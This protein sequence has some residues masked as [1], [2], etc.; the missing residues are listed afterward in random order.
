MGKAPLLRR[1][2]ALKLAIAGG[3]LGLASSIVAIVRTTTGYGDAA[4]DDASRAKLIALAP[5]QLIVVKHLARRVCAADQ[6]GVVT[7]DETDVAG[8]VDAYVAKMPPKLR[9]DLLR[10][11]QYIEQLAPVAIGMTSRFT[12]LSPPDQDKVLASIESSSIELLRGGFDGVKALLF[13][14]FYRDP[15]TWTVIG[16]DGPRVGRRED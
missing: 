14:G 7:S 8:F 3:A 12:Q 1:R 15:R 13:M 9:R 2:T 10:F 6:A 5:W 4:L 11:L 16:Y